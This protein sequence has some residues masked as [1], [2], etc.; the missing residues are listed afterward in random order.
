MIQC[1]ALELGQDNIRG[2]SHQAEED[3]D[4]D[5]LPQ[6]LQKRQDPANSEEFQMFG[7][8]FHYSATS[9]EPLWVS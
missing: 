9:W 7:L 6:G 8:F 3:H 4:E 1:I 5:Q 2:T